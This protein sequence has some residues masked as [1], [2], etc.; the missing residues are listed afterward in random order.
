M[1]PFATTCGIF[2]ENV[3]GCVLLYLLKLDRES[4]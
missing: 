1:E 4:Y 3:C 2:G